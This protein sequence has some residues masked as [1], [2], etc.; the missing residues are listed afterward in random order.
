MSNCLSPLGW[1]AHRSRFAAEAV[2]DDFG[3]L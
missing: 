2:R 3:L 1:V